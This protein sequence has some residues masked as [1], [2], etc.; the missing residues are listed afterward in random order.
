MSMIMSNVRP[1][2]AYSLHNGNAKVSPRGIPI[3]PSPHGQSQPFRS[4]L[5]SHSASAYNFPLVK[6]QIARPHSP[7]QPVASER[8][9]STATIKYSHKMAERK[10]RKE[11]ND[12]FDELRVLL[13]FKHG[14]YSKWEILTGASSHI[15]TLKEA[16][17]K[18]LVQKEILHRELG[19]PVADLMK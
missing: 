1:P 5:H 11:M 6:L 14:N 17:I 9:D 8:L 2:F 15:E 12:T 4:V 18:L 13:P 7:Q 3:A 19:L 16:R 10:R